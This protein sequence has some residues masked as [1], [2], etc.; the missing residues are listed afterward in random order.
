[1][2]SKLAESLPQI[3]SVGTATPP[4]RYTQ[5]EVLAMF[6]SVDPR[7]R[8]FYLNGH[9]K[10]R[11]LV[12][13]DPVNGRREPES[14]EALIT[15]HRRWSVRLGKEAIDACL[16]PLGLTPADVDYLACVTTTG[17]LCPGVSAYLVK[18]HG[19]REDVHRIDVVGMGCNAGVNTLQ[20]V[21]AFCATNPGKLALML[22]V[23]VCSAAYVNDGTLRSAI[24]NSL[25]G[26][27]AAAV[28]LRTGSWVNPP[29]RK[30]GPRILGF[31]SHTISDAMMTMRFDLYEGKL[32]FFL[33]RDIPYFIGS[34]VEKP[35]G[36][37]LERFGLKRRQ[38]AH[39][40]VHS[41]GRKVIDSVKYNIGLTDHDVRHTLSVLR[42]YGNVSSGSFLFSLEKLLNERVVK[43]GDFGVL[44]AMGPGVAIETALVQW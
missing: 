6:D 12:L 3:L 31:E 29:G 11:H 22:C 18:E 4:D 21:A 30:Y 5:E 24:V 10:T 25:F 36:R 8:G 41:G 39:W 16:S 20:P 19:F 37:L 13:P 34:H 14:Q 38:I 23:E 15:K 27:G 32:S 7:V 17:Y 40:V 9:I 43:P 2:V 44:M 35:I 33:D 42:D 26:D 1:M 28:V